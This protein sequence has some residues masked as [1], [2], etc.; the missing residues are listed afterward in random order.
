MTSDSATAIFVLIKK[1][2]IWNK[3]VHCDTN[4]KENKTKQKK[5]Q[6]IVNTVPIKLNPSENF[7]SRGAELFLCFVC[8]FSSILYIMRVIFY[9]Y[10]ETRNKRIKN[11][12]N[13]FLF[14]FY[15]KNKIKR[16]NRP[17]FSKEFNWQQINC[18]IRN[19]VHVI[20][21][22]WYELLKIIIKKSSNC[23]VGMLEPKNFCY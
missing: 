15:F 8:L 6:N 22:R 12:F 9:S 17:Q 13:Y 4:K 10:V 3:L 19:Y 5:N 2:N 18:Y 21:Y 7:N 16:E 1:N 23:L 20:L 11:L 14:S